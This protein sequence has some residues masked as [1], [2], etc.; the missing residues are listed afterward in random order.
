VNPRDG[1]GRQ[2]RARPNLYDLL[3]TIYRRR[4]DEVYAVDKSGVRA[5]DLL[6]VIDSS[7]ADTRTLADTHVAPLKALFAI[8]QRPFEELESAIAALYDD[9]FVETCSEEMLPLIAEPLAV[10][11]IEALRKGHADLR[12]VIANIVD[13]RRRKG[14]ARA[15]EE[16]GSEAT[17]W[18]VQVTDGLESLAQTPRMHPQ[19]ARRAGFADLRRRPPGALA[20]GAPEARPVSGA[21]VRAAG[22]GVRAATIDVL[23]TKG[24]P[25]TGV[26]PGWPDPGERRRRTFS[27]LGDDDMLMRPASTGDDDGA[28]SFVKP[29]TRAAARADLARSGRIEGLAVR[30]LHWIGSSEPPL[31]VADL[32]HWDVP[33][34]AGAAA[35]TVYVDPELGRLLLPDEGRLYEV[36]YTIVAHDGIGAAPVS[37]PWPGTFDQTFL[38]APADTSPGRGRSRRLEAQLLSRIL[39]DTAAFTAYRRTLNALDFDAYFEEWAFVQDFYERSYDGTH[40]PPRRVPTAGELHRRF[41]SFPYTPTVLSTDRLIARLVQARGD[42]RGTETDSHGRVER[43]GSLSG[44]LGAAAQAQGSVRI[45][46]ATSRT[47]RSPC[48]WMFAPGAGLTALS[49]EAAPGARPAI[50]GELVLAPAAH[51]LTVR[52]L[53]VDLRGP[54]VCGAL[55]NLTVERSTLRPARGRDGSFALDRIGDGGPARPVS[56]RFSYL[57]GARLSDATELVV[58]DSVVTDPVVKAGEDALGP[59][60]T[61]RRS[62]FLGDVEAYRLTASD[63][64]FDAAVRAEDRA[65][66]YLRYCAIRS[67]E[68]L[69]QRYKCIVSNEQVL[70]STKY[71]RRGFARVRDDARIRTASSEGSEIGAYGSYADAARRA[72]LMSVIEEFLPERVAPRVRYLT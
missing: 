19:A 71:G 6:A 55:G 62:T 50:D 39:G 48:G 5:R 65:H 25:V 38:V 57:G 63:V 40:D 17:G 60:I 4:D 30:E 67:T 45:V 7:H 10:R 69:P 59:Q 41:P 20:S 58:E 11:D 51:A 46:L 49:I 15:L 16:L 22:G 66:G 12:A 18:T 26:E 23:R 24:A 68:Q 3:P 64:L 70:I 34:R 29:L 47:L 61:A 54:L 2:K 1:G 44:A 72:N 21:D 31:L 8:L 43:F 33:A 9:W 14:V 37:R 53:G 35:R 32:S 27:P 56:V 52:L 42:V 13:H 28:R 36:D